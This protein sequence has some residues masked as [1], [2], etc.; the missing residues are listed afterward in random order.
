M[1]AQVVAMPAVSGQPKKV[2]IFGSTGSVGGNTIDLIQRQPQVFEVVALSARSNVDLLAAQARDLG[3]QIAVIADETKYA[4]L[5]EALRGSK[6]EVGAGEC[7]LAEAAARPADWVMAAITGTAG[8]RSTI[9]AAE[10]GAT[11]ALANKESLVAAGALLKR[12]IQ[13]AGGKLLPVDSELSAIFQIFDPDQTDQIERLV[14]TGSGGP[15]RTWS[16]EQMAHATLAQALNHPNWSMGAK[17]TIDSATMMNKSLELIEAHHLFDMPSDKIEILIHRQ[18]IIHSMVAYRDGSMLAQ[19]GEPDMRTPIAVALAWPDR[20]ASPTKPLDLTRIAQLD[21][22]VLDLA[23]FPAVSLARQALHHGGG[24]PIVLNAANEVAVECFL[25]NRLGF[26]KIVELVEECLDHAESQ[27]LMTPPGG[28][29][30]VV[31][32]DQQARQLARNVLGRRL[33]QN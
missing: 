20:M 19:L 21:F 14:L 31:K 23:R 10:A 9:A 1:P 2:S 5:C 26:L 29:D 30:E 6:V 27:G 24:A 33:K 13:K 17:I 28:I 12:T 3:A 18:S 22:E 11:I 4:A 16:R 32:L 15:F 7:A 8:L 25:Q